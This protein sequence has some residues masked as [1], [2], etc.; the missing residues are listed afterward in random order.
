MSRFLVIFRE[1]MVHD[2]KTGYFVV[3]TDAPVAESIRYSQV[4]PMVQV[5]ILII[6]LQ[7][8]AFINSAY[9]A[10]LVEMSQ[11]RRTTEQLFTLARLMLSFGPV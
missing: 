2:K 10:F 8:F 3:T 11:K 6:F 5:Q 1:N 4:R 9:S 7:F